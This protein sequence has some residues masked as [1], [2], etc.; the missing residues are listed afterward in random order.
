MT[1][2]FP[3]IF[4][5]FEHETL[6]FRGVFDV[7]GRRYG[8][9]EK[10]ESGTLRQQAMRERNRLQKLLKQSNAER[11][12][13]L[14]PLC[15]NV[16]WMKARL[17]AAREE[18]GEAPLM[19][20]YQHGEKQSGVTEN[21]AIRAYESLFRSYVTGLSKILDAL[22]SAAAEAAIEKAPKQTKLAMI[23]ARREKTG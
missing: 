17:D 5:D 21:P 15:E 20:E 14:R 6:R 1:D 12:Q 18:I 8:M 22:P 3:R 9:A 13:A 4:Q 11:A 16:G 19:V 7:C 23:K 2:V 10:T